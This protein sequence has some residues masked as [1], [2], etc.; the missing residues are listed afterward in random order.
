[1]GAPV[2]SAPEQ[3]IFSWLSKGLSTVFYRRKPVIIGK[4]GVPG[5][6]GPGSLGSVLL[7]APVLPMVLPTQVLMLSIVA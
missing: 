7:T 1:M 6:A 4:V 5:E 2:G 3:R